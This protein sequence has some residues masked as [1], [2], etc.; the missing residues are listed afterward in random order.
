MALCECTTDCKRE[1][2]EVKGYEVIC[3]KK[4]VVDRTKPTIEPGT[5]GAKGTW[6]FYWSRYQTEPIEDEN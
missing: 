2:G 6:P 3:K 1:A 5:P 4:T